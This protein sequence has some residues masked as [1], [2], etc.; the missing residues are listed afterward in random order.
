MGYDCNSDVINLNLT[1]FQPT[2]TTGFSTCYLYR[3]ALDFKLSPRTVGNKGSRL[4]FTIFANGSYASSGRVHI[5]AY[6]HLRDPNVRL[7]NLTGVTAL[8]KA[9]IADWITNEQYNIQTA[10]T[11]TMELLTY[12][13]L[14]FN[15]VNRQSLV[16]DAWSCLLYTSPSPRDS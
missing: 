13:G 16:A 9:E 8:S 14:G 2:S 15:V 5:S 10:N 7:Y 12:N 4:V 3:P 1:Y 11:Y 6:P